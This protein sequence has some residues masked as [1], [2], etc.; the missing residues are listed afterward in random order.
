MSWAILR[1][2]L[3][4]KE[5]YNPPKLGL[6]EETLIFG[7]CWRYPREQAAGTFSLHLQGLS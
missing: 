5:Q 2:V 1:H 4:V 7:K 3:G 6:A